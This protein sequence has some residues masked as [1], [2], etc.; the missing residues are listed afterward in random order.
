M[1]LFRILP[2]IAIGAAVWLGKDAFKE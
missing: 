2:I 1:S